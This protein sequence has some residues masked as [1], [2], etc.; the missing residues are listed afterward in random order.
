MSPKEEENRM[1]EVVL[2][3]VACARDCLDEPP[4]FGPRR[5]IDAA[6]RLIK[7]ADAIGVADGAMTRL[8]EQIADRGNLLGLDAATLAAWLDQL[9]VELSVEAKA[10]NVAALAEFEK[11]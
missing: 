2:F 7:A 1:F 8:G 6:G 5:M 3:L 4:I 9:L 10:R 11:E